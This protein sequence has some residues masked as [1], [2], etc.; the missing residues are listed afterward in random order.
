MSDTDASTVRY[1]VADAVATITLNRPDAMNA[2][3]AEMKAAL[4]DAL[5]RA[6]DDDAVRAVLLTGSGRGFCSGQDLREHVGNLEA[7]RGLH[8]T[9]REHYNPIIRALVETPKPIVAAVNGIAAGAGAGVAFACDLRI[10]AESA[11]FLMAFA[12]VGLG[13]DSGTSWTLQ[14]LVGRAQAMEMLMLAEPVAAGQ[15]MALGLVHRVVG[16]AE[17]ADSARELAGRL[18]QGPTVAYGAVKRAVNF[19]SVHDL[20]EA[21]EREAELQEACAETEDHKEATLAFVNK[22]KPTF[23]GR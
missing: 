13:P 12:R 3:T 17:L 16:D 5:V 2:L 1:E 4:L 21:L 18:A 11:A 19:A 6:R 9:V 15:A 23:R 8:G 7:G 10:A 22:Q 14:R 20:D